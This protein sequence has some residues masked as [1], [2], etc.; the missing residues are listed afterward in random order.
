[1][2]KVDCMKCKRFCRKDNKCTKTKAYILMYY[3]ECKLYKPLD[4]LKHCGLYKEK[5]CS[6]VDGLL[7]P[8]EEI[9]N[10]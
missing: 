5:G 3:R 1:M 8:C 10:S 7:C 9:V 2:Q 6:H 4:P